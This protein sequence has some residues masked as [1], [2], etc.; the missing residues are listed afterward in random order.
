MFP[1]LSPALSTWR[2]ANRIIYQ[3]DEVFCLGPECESS[4]E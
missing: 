3:L 4:R 1:I 2:L